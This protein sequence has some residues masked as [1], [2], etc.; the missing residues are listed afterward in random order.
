MAW[1]LSGVCM[2]LPNSQHQYF[3]GIDAGTTG[4]KVVICSDDGRIAGMGYREY[5][6]LHPQPGWVEQDVH[7]IWRCLCEASHEALA[8]AHVAP[9]R[10]RSVGVS[11][12][13]G[14]L[15]FCDENYEP[16]M[17]SVVYSDLRS[18][19]QV[20][21]IKQ[22]I[23]TEKYQRLTG[24]APSSY[25]SYPKMKWFIDERPDLFEKTAWILNGQEWF[26]LKLGSESPV[27]DP[28][29]RTADGLMNLAKLDW[30]PDLCR[31]IGLPLSKLPPMGTP[32]QQVGTLSAKAAKETG[33][34]MGTPICIGAGDQ[35]CAAVGAGIVH[36]GMAE[37][38]IGTAMVMVAHIDSLRSDPR[39]RVVFGGSGLP[40][41]W[42]M[43]GFLLTAGSALKWWRNTYA[44]AEMRAASELGL[45]VYDLI[46]LEAQKSRLGSGGQLFFPYFNGMLSPTVHDEAKGGSLGLAHNHNRQDMA[47][48]VMEGVVLATSLIVDAMEDVLGKPF[49]IL[50]LSGGAAKSHFWN[51]MQADVYGR[52]L[53]TLRVS[54]CTALGATILGAVGA[55]HFA[56]VE[57]GTEHMVHPATRI[58]PQQ[59]NHERYIELK[60]I[61]GDTV[62]AMIDKGI[63]RRI[64]AFQHQEVL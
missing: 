45:D 33:L 21:W 54:E 63:Y 53:E 3:A 39:G 38:T 22:E 13:R 44:Q 9:D 11:S 17:H 36:E 57:E 23:G 16:V 4:V 7:Q 51:Q 56:S 47:R 10:I 41:K 18:A 1:F 8:K 48:S 5:P 50:R 37:I 59:Q 6:C 2:I 27:T 64:T 19:P 20:E 15:I 29:S 46:T 12:Q 35:Q 40:G 42:D 32:A 55:G 14:T 31:R 58:E 62:H 34:A 30:S 28:A 52:P 26:L 43:E 24:V 60:G 49:D 25:W 61:F